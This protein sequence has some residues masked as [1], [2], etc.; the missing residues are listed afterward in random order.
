MR[1]KTKTKTG[2]DSK[3]GKRFSTHSRRKK[4]PLTKFNI[5]S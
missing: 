4:K 3:H 5:F 1:K 2:L